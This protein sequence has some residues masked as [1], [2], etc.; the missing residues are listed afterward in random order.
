M[1]SQLRETLGTK[2]NVPTEIRENV[3]AYI[4]TL[5]AEVGRGAAVAAA[6]EARRQ[7]EEKRKKREERRNQKSAI[8]VEQLSPG[9]RERRLRKQNRE[10]LKRLKEVE[11][12]KEE[13]RKQMPMIVLNAAGG[14]EPSS[15]Y[16]FK[17][18]LQQIIKANFRLTEKW[19]VKADGQRRTE[20]ERA[21]VIEQ[22]R[23]RFQNG[24]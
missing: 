5:V 4:N 15:Y 16:L 13:K 12:L 7:D 17:S 1:E 24:S 11:K 8:P 23:D 14:V 3:A 10:E 22:V 19:T 9:A 21:H 6:A 20:E 18:E 2:F